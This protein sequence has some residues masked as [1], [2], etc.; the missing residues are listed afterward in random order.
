M[1]GEE[2]TQLQYLEVQ[3]KLAR[4]KNYGNPMVGN[5]T[6]RQMLLEGMGTM[7]M[8]REQKWATLILF[9]L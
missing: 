3:R 8:P 9:S 6:N 4:F 7:N 2:E 1:S 5:S